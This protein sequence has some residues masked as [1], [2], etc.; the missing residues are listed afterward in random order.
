MSDKIMAFF[1]LA[2][3]V[4]FL[5]VVAWFVPDIDLIIVIAFVSLLATYD[6]WRSF[7]DPG[8]HNDV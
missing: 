7:R 4:T 5:G 8:K 2:T 3:M 1:A 6:F